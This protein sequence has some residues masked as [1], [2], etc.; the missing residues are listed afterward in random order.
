MSNLEWKPSLSHIHNSQI[1][2]FIEFIQQ[3]HGLNLK[4]SDALYDWSIKNPEDFWSLF[5]QFSQIKASKLWDK[6]LVNGHDMLQ[7][8][9]FV[10][11]QLNFAENLLKRRD[12]SLAIVFRGEDKV[13][14]KYTF[15]ELYQQVAQVANGL[16]A[17]GIKKSD[18]VAGFM[19]NLPQ[20][21]IAMLATTSIGA[22]WSS[23]SP[24]FGIQGVLD[25]FSQIEPKILFTIEGYFY[26]G[27]TID[28]MDKVAEI[29]KRLPT[30]KQV[31]ITNYTQ[32]TA[33]I[34]NINH[35]IWWNEF[36]LS[37]QNNTINFEQVSFD[38]PLVIMYSSGTT[39]VP[40]CIVHSVGGTLIQHLKEHILHTNLTYNDKIFYYTTCGWM[41][42]NWLV[43]AL[44]V[45]ATLLLYDGAPMYPTPDVLW[46]YAKEYKM[47]VFGTSA[48]YLA[49][50]EKTGYKPGQDQ[51]LSSLY[52]ILSTGSPL[53]PE[54]YDFVYK[55]IKSDLCL[56]S[57]SG[58]TDIISC[59]ALGNPT[60]PVYRGELQQRGFGMAVKIY[61]DEG[62][63]AQV[64][65]KGEL[66]CTAPFPSQPIYFWNDA[67]KSK[68]KKAYFEKFPNI[69]CHGD[70]AALTRHNGIII[71]GRSDTTLNPGGVRIGTAEIYR[72]VETITDIVEAVVVGHEVAGDVKVILFVKMQANKLLTDE[73]RKTICQKIKHGASPRHVP[74]QII[75]VNDIPRTVSG[76]IAELAVKQVIHGEVVKNKDALINPDSLKLFENLVE[77]NKA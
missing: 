41:M 7:A 59:F 50:L 13:E 8:K 46:R 42:W 65:E 36:T 68:Y 10:G 74:A 9:W 45:G 43:S 48:K 38:H 4:D 18:H 1:A 33:D 51:D 28:C 56:A 58:G 17:I 76:K 15:N 39:G 26:N 3:N 6:V 44:A 47:N 60:K 23:C 54:S 12:D 62:N 77:L 20:T 63:E 31:I 25:R 24:D 2:K 71:Y 11:S 55:E 19:P 34:S 40:K 14:W 49:S 5:W 64:D 70:Y 35:A 67:D 27:K 57:I 66:V 30:L 53:L 22:I 61:T 37:H 32:N 69:W 21:T 73:L 52:A 72:Q 16:K 75:A 29:V